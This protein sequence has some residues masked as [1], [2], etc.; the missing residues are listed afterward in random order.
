M[1]P[2]INVKIQN[3]CRVM[4]DKTFG[5]TAFAAQR[6]EFIFKFG[7]RTS[8]GKYLHDNSPNQRGKMQPDQRPIAQHEQ[9]AE[10]CEQHVAEMKNQCKIS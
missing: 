2:V 9:S 7:Q 1:K 6:A 3:I 4:F 5:I 10:D 8:Q